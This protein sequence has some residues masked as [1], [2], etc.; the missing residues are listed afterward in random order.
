SVIYTLSLHRRSSDL[1]NENTVKGEC[2]A[3]AVAGA[4]TAARA[5]TQAHDFPG[6]GSDGHPGALETRDR[7]TTRKPM[8]R[9]RR[10]GSKEKRLRSEE[11]TSEHQSPGKL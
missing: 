10:A 1:E 9:L 4:I 11:H 2:G 8:K 3:F 7:T 5:S 6:A